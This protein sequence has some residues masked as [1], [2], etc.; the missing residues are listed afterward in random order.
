MNLLFDEKKIENKD[1]QRIFGRITSFFR[2]SLFSIFFLSDN[3]FM[4]YIQNINLYIKIKKHI[5]NIFYNIESLFIH[6]ISLV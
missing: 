5:Y 6:Y 1:S 2:L 4:I 3:L